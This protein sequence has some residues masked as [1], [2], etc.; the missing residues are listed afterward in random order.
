MSSSTNSKDGGEKKPS[1]SELSS[2]HPPNKKGKGLR[3]LSHSLSWALR[4]K[5]VELGFHMTS[6]GYVAVDEILNSNHSKFRGYTVT[7]IREVVET[8]DKQRYKLDERPASQFGHGTEGT[9]LCIRANQGHSIAHVDPNLLLERLS[10][11]ELA[12]IPM[13]VHGTYKEAW[14]SIQTQGLK[15][16]T[17]NHIHFA[18]GLPKDD[19][20]ISGMRKSCEVFVYIDAKKCANDSVTFYR[21][22]NGVLLTAGV[23]DEGILPVNYFSHVTDTSGTILMKNSP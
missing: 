7:D 4:H 12:R 16:M 9:V 20:V 15:R 8:S 3:Q 1:S 23:N 14:S 5:A 19:G 13:I 18:S 21:S 10:T 11:E 17:R 22:D 6:D 2:A